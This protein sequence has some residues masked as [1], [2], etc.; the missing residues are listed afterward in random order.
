MRVEDLFLQIRSHSYSN[1]TD[2]I[3]IGVARKHLLNEMF[4]FITIEMLDAMNMGVY[5][6]E[7]Y[8]P[9]IF[10][11]YYNHCYAYGYSN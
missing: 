1:S 3:Y 2:Y 9:Q 6:H 5:V 8:S 4:A 10:D 11:L 7:V